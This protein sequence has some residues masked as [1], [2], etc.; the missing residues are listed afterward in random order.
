MARKDDLRNNVEDYNGI[1]FKSPALAFS[2]A[3]FLLSFAWHATDR[4]L[5]GQDPGLQ[6]S[7]ESGLRLA[8]SHRRAQHRRLGVTTTY[9]LIIVMFFRDP[10]GAWG[11][12]ARAGNSGGCSDSHP[13]RRL[14][15]SAC[16]PVA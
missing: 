15:I 9:D 12:A 4:R 7:R 10:I 6:C 8:R 13:R 5:H 14:F 3:I 16:F 1:G 11:S 2:L